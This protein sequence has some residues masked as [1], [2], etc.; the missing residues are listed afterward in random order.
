MAAY[1]CTFEAMQL[2]TSARWLASNQQ[3]SSPMVDNIYHV[4][5]FYKNPVAV[6]WVPFL[7]VDLSLDF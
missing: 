1:D 5:C 7:D 6:H 4:L 3:A 2:T